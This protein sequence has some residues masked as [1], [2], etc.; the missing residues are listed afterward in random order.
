MGN[1]MEDIKS[2]IT[3]VKIAFNEKKKLI[4]SKHPK[5]GDYEKHL[6]NVLYGVWQCMVLK[7][8]VLEKEIKIELKPLLERT[9][10]DNKEEQSSKWACS[11]RCWGGKTNVEELNKNNT[12]DKAH[13]TNQHLPVDIDWAKS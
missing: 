2:R 3:W 1:H 10:K 12:A 13:H 7:L 5:L 8:E 9:N 6:W 4:I 11:Q